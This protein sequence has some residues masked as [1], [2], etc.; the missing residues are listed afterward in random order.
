MNKNDKIRDLFTAALNEAISRGLIN[1][2]KVE[3]FRVKFECELFGKRTL[4]SCDDDGHLNGHK[5]QVIDLP[6]RHVCLPPLPP[7][8][9]DLL[10]AKKCSDFYGPIIE[11]TGGV[12]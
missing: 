9:V 7:Q 2:H 10:L 12:Q 3:R 1:H 4:V 5:K 8:V 6:G 11:K